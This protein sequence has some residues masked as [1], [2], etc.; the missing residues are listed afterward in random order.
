MRSD[1][2]GAR[3]AACECP[4]LDHS[5]RQSKF[6]S[7]WCALL[8]QRPFGGSCLSALCNPVALPCQSSLALSSA[9]TPAPV[10]ELSSV[11][12]PALVYPTRATT[13]MGAAARLSRYVCLCVRTCKGQAGQ[14][15]KWIKEAGVGGG[16]L[17]WVGRRL[18]ALHR[19]T[20]AAQRLE[21]GRQRRAPP[22]SHREPFNPPPPLPPTH[23]TPTPTHPTP[24]PT[25]H[26]PHTQPR[27]TSSRSRRSRAMRPLSR[28]RS[29][30]I[31]FSPM[32]LTCA[33]AAAAPNRG[34]TT[35]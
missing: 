17:G 16:G 10:S 5:S 13:G 25:T 33:R 21:P 19:C 20:P 23:P 15:Q 11:D 14:R 6:L 28:R 35:E 27:P 34:W 8:P 22:H 3:R 9:S 32:P 18:F 31:C 4:R 7:G 2:L 26:P 30:S 24:T 1:E 29:T 12:F